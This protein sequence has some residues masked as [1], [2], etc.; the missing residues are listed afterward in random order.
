MGSKE[1]SDPGERAGQAPL[2]VTQNDTPE[3]PPPAYEALPPYSA[4]PAASSSA[5]A[6]LAAASTTEKKQVLA[7]DTT[8]GYLSLSLTDDPL[9]LPIPDTCTAHLKLLYA[10]RALREDVGYSDGL[11]KIA[12]PAEDS[13]APEVSLDVM[14]KLREKRWAIYLARAVHRYEAWWVSL[15]GR[16]VTLSDMNVKGGIEY[17]MFPFEDAGAGMAWEEKMLMPLGE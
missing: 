4:N 8:S 16:E 10:F 13:K 7:Q 5:A 3:N 12:D 17:E 1:Q 2:L 9:D 15:G 6:A 11:W 14:S